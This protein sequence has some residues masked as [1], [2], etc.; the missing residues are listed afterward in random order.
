[1][2]FRYENSQKLFHCMNFITTLIRFSIRRTFTVGTIII[3]AREKIGRHTHSHAHALEKAIHR[4]ISTIL[5]PTE[6]PRWKY[7]LQQQKENCLKMC[8][9]PTIFFHSFLFT[10]YLTFMVLLWKCKRARERERAF[11]AIYYKHSMAL[12]GNSL[13]SHTIHYYRYRNVLRWRMHNFIFVAVHLRS[14]LR[15]CVMQCSALSLIHW[16]LSQMHQRSEYSENR[17]HP[18][19]MYEFC[20]CIVYVYK[21]KSSHCL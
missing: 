3:R 2:V 11:L 20:M 21:W 13:H 12:E 6:T 19:L 18:L 9:K 16:K 14:V 8:S 5:E 17:L 7:I 1:M 15:V 4:T 10:W